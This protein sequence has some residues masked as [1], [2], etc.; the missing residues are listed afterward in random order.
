KKEMLE[1]FTGWE[2]QNKYVIKNGAGEQMYYAYESSDVCERV[3]CKEG[4]SFTIYIVDNT[5]RE[6]MCVS[7]EFKCC[8]GWCCCAEPGSC[9]A[10]EVTVETLS[11]YEMGSVSQRPSSCVPAYQVQDHN[12]E[13]FLNIDIPYC[14]DLV[15]D[16]KLFTINTFDE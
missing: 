8:A 16:D 7:R 6:V 4:R 2:T 11:G 13:A 14:C 12:K 1:I 3:C 5:G 15:C 10:H 9:A